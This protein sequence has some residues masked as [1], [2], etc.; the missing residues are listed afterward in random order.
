MVLPAPDPIRIRNHVGVYKPGD[1]II[2]GI[3]IRNHPH[4][5]IV[6]IKRDGDI[7]R[8]THDI[9]H[10]RISWI[11]TL[12]A[13]KKTRQ[14]P[15]DAIRILIDGGNKECHV[16]ESDRIVLMDE[17]AEQEAGPGAARTEITHQED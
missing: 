3:P 7:A 17:V 5:Q 14:S 6:E 1:K 16:C 10:P 2:H 9:N 12:V 8:I 11:K 15:Q 4:L 13:L